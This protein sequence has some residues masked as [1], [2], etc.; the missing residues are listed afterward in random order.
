[1]SKKS[2]PNLFE[3]DSDILK[4]NDHFS[5]DNNSFVDK[6]SECNSEKMMIMLLQLATVFVGD[7]GESSPFHKEKKSFLIKKL[8]QASVLR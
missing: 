1:M 5:S 4:P 8:Q 3:S 7:Q 6:E 2:L